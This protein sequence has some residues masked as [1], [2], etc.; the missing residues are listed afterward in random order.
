MPPQLLP[1][2]VHWTTF[3][4]QA[5]FVSDSVRG[6]RDAILIGVFL[7]GLVLLVFLRTFRLTLIAVAAIPLTVAI[8]GL[9]LGITG[10]TINL[11]TL[12]GVAAAQARF[13]TLP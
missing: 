13:V 8:V 7:A 4:D 3:Y 5:R 12:A 2:D 6:T 11:M 10:Q 9:A 1:A